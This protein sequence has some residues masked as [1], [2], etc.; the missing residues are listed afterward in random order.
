MGICKYCFS[1]QARPC[2]VVPASCGYDAY[3]EE[4]PTLQQTLTNYDVS[5]SAKRLVIP[6]EAVSLSDEAAWE[7]RGYVSNMP[8]ERSLLDYVMLRDAEDEDERQEAAVINGKVALV[9]PV[10]N[11]HRPLLIKQ[12]ACSECHTILPYR[13]FSEEDAR[14]RNMAEEVFRVVLIANTSAGKTNLTAAMYEEFANGKA[15][16]DLQISETL[17]SKYHWNT[18]HDLKVLGKVPPSTQHSTPP[19]SIEFESA[20]GSRIAVDIVDTRGEI[21]K[22]PIDLEPCLL[23]DLIIFLV[24]IR[25]H[26]AAGEDADAADYITD[27]D[28]LAKYV[29]ELSQH[30]HDKRI[31]LA[32]SK[33]DL[34]AEAAKT[35]M[36]SGDAAKQLPPEHFHANMRNLRNYRFSNDMD[37]FMDAVCKEI[38]SQCPPEQ[39][40]SQHAQS[41]VSKIITELVGHCNNISRY[42]TD[43]MCVAPLG[44][45]TFRADDGTDR[46]HTDRLNPQ[47][48]SELVELIKL[49]GGGNQ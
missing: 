16:V 36:F 7:G 21:T 15:G 12:L 17:F 2:F 24:D 31:I 18:A 23:A 27:I 19:L 11:A 45:G 48:I 42:Q 6:P 22:D 35:F 9:R 3:L 28:R 13:T 32:F 49:Y 20:S 10:D 8:A 38:N 33:C 34:Y 39:R 25:A 43:I 40:I 14:S 4:D 44:T 5:F 46:I 30:V 1:K 29:Y 47:Y 37:S 41:I 26:D